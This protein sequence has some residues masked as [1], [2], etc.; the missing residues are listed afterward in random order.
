MTLDSRVPN[1]LF[2]E[3]KATIATFEKNA[4]YCSGS[5]DVVISEGNLEEEGATGEDGEDAKKGHFGRSC[6][7]RGMQARAQE[8]IPQENLKR[9]VNLKSLCAR[10]ST[11]KLVSNGFLVGIVSRNS[12]LL[13][14]GS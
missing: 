2:C 11:W 14:S 12:A 5:R 7:R 6:E 8:T 10:L 4:A 1:T 13:S 3:A 9:G